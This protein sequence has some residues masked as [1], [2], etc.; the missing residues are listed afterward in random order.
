[1]NKKCGCYIRQE[2]CGYIQ[3]VFGGNILKVCCV[4][5]QQVCGGYIW[6]K[7]T[8]NLRGNF[9]LLIRQNFNFPRPMSFFFPPEGFFFVP[10]T[11]WV[12]LQVYRVLIIFTKFFIAF[13]MCLFLQVFICL[14]YVFFYDDH[15]KQHKHCKT[16]T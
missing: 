6:W 8:Q 9:G 1:M 16:S 5:S 10:S 11:V 7:K 15:F 2:F 3:Q 14:L 12:F 4:Y 13:D